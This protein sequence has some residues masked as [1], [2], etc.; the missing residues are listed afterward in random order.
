M[1]NPAPFKFDIFLSKIQID[2]IQTCRINLYSI[3]NFSARLW[4]IQID[5]MC[6]VLCERF[7]AHTHLPIYIIANGIECSSS[8]RMYTATGYCYDVSDNASSNIVWKICVLWGCGAR[9]LVLRRHWCAKMQNSMWTLNRDECHIH[10][11]VRD[12]KQKTIV[13]DVRQIREH[14]SEI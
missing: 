4:N 9:I 11:L 1:K 10:R 12:L 8:S 13:N 5:W 14:K 2:N 3:L 7:G 6:C